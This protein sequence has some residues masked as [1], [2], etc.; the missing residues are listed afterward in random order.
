VIAVALAYMI[1]AGVTQSVVYFVTPSELGRARGGQGLPPGRMV[2]RGSV[3]WEPRTLALTFALSDGKAT[4]PVRHTGAPPD[5]FGEGAAPSSRARG[6]PR[7]T[8]GDA[9]HGQALGE[10]K[11]PHERARR[12]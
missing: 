2:E 4:V 12:A 3:R 11:A 7:A 9:H 5:L 8:S 10:Y 1:Y 6:V